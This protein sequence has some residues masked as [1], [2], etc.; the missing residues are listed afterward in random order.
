MTLEIFKG[1]MCFLRSCL[2]L[3]VYICNN[4]CIICVHRILYMELNHAVSHVKFHTVSS[5]DS[6]SIVIPVIGAFITSARHSLS[7]AFVTPT[8]IC[9][10]FLGSNEFTCT[11]KT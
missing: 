8:M 1:A 5:S 11:L 3:F 7:Q 9:V 6:V 2:N 10:I 4:V